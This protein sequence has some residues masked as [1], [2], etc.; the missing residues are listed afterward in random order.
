MNCI[1][2]VTLPFAA[3]MELPEGF[4]YNDTQQQISIGIATDDLNIYVVQEEIITD[5]VIHPCTNEPMIGM[6][7]Y[8]NQIRMSGNLVYRV[9]VNAL[10]SSYNFMVDAAIA[11]DEGYVSSDGIIQIKVDDEGVMKDYMVLGYL[12][13]NEDKLPPTLD[14][15]NVI[16]DNYSI[17]QNNIDGKSV[18]NI[19]GEF[20][21]VLV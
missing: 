6:T 20:S 10:M 1:N 13:A 12:N 16:L 17:V 7:V 18:L 21:F 5:N 2:N 11:E 4:Y 15:I 3:I 9:S 8:V 14:N 19:K